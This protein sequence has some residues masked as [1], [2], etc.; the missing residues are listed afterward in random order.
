MKPLHI[1]FDIALLASLTAVGLGTLGWWRDQEDAALRTLATAAAVRT[2]QTH[3]AMEA[4][5][6]GDQLNSDGYP[7]SID[8]RWFEG[9]TPIN[10]LAPEDSPWVELASRDECD[11]DH[12]KQMSFTGGRHAMFWYNPKKG[13]IRARVPEQASDLRIKEAYLA[14]NGLTPESP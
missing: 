14:A 6:G 9:G 4:T 3:I 7:A 1:A 2:I 8:P 12:P 5:L 10:R 11:R 13:I